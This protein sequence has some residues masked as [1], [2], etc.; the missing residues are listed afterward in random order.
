MDDLPL[1]SSGLGV[2]YLIKVY[3]PEGNGLYC[4]HGVLNA[5]NRVFLMI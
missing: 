1:V 4:K 2:A 5:F 3:S